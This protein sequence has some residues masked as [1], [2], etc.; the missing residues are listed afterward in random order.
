MSIGK[1]KNQFLVISTLLTCTFLAIFEHAFEINYAI[2]T[3][4]KISFFLLNIGIYTI[5]FKDFHPKDVFGIRRIEKKE[6]LRLLLLG[7]S[8]ASIVL[9]A[10]LSLQPFFDV[11]KIKEDLTDRLGITAAG[12]IFVGLYVQP[13][14]I[15]C[16]SYTNGY[17]LV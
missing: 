3:G 4:V 13:F 8:S 15:C 2:K 11:T 7:A 16:L 5:L 1:S 9:I 14:A 17:A 12:F 10:Y 6:W